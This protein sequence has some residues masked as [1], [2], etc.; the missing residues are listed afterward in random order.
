MDEEKQLAVEA[1][2]VAPALSVK[3]AGEDKQVYVGYVWKTGSQFFLSKTRKI[4][5][6]TWIETRNYKVCQ[7]RVKAEVKRDVSVSTIRRWLDYPEMQEYIKERFEDLGIFNSW[8]KEKWIRI[9]TE[10]IRANAEH[11]Q[12]KEEVR[13]YDSMLA[14]NSKDTDA[15]V[16]LANSRAKM[17]VASKKRLANG[18][19][20]AMK[21]IG[22]MK[23]WEAQPATTFNQSIHIV[24]ANGKE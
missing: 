12:A 23:G 20:Y 16:G 14:R 9:M 15:Q 8:T 1:T 7:E 3:S 6:D 24:Q 17:L 18:D 4:I 19:L 2:P 10:H 13:Q 22:S 5:A 21:L 11:E